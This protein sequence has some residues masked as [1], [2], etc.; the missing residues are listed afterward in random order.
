VSNLVGNALTHGAH[1]A[2]VRL[3]LTEDDG[4]VELVVSNRGA[5]IPA[6]HVAQLFEP[7]WQAPANGQTSRRKGLGLGLWIVREIVRHHGGTI[8]VRSAD[9]VTAFTVR[10]P[11]QPAG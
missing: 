1:E 10:L 2:P 11:R 3:L 7:F 5:T 6:E 8:D 4:S 9:E